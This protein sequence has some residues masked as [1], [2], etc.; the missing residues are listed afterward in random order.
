MPDRRKDS[1]G[2]A[3]IVTTSDAGKR[4]AHRKHATL[5]TEHSKPEIDNK[6]Q[7]TALKIT[8]IW[9]ARFVGTQATPANT[10]TSEKN[11]YP[12]REIPHEKQTQDETNNQRREIKGIMK[13]APRSIN[14]LKT[15]R[16]TAN[17]ENEYEN[18]DDEP[19]N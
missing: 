11:A 7:K 4:N 6:G 1:K 10:A 18:E 2:S 8:E 13:N 16:L 15:V 12:Y 14:L 9:Y 19:L 5:R 3:S 17:P